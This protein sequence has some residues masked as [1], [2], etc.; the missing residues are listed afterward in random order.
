MQRIG[1][2]DLTARSAWR[3]LELVEDLRREDVAA[4]DRQVRGRL[5]GLR[6][7]D[8]PADLAQPAV[9]DALVD[10]LA[11]DHAVTARLLLRNF[12]HGDDRTVYLLVGVDELTDAWTIADDDVVRQD[13][14]ERLVADEVLRDEHRVA[15]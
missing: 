9:V 1:Q 15:Q 4:D 14:R 11:G 12:H 13:H 2:L 6:L 5:P 7:F 10:G 3:L 8:E